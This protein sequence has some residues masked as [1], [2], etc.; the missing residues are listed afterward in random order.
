M[1]NYNYQLPNMFYCG[2][3]YDCKNLQDAKEFLRQD[4]G[5]KRLPNGTTFWGAN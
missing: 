5:V 2:T 1:K 4:L 3:I